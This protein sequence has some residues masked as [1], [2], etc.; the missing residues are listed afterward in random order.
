MSGSRIVLSRQTI[1]FLLLVL[2][3][4]YLFNLGMWFSKDLLLENQ[5]LYFQVLQLE[6][7]IPA[8]SAIVVGVFIFKDTAY[9]GKPR[10]FFL[11]YLLVTA[12]A[13]IM[14]LGRLFLGLDRVDYQ[15][16]ALH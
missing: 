13:A 3:L 16:H 6:M 15:Q 8:F 9:L 14:I 10:I 7:M 12:F 5:Q 1:V 2:G 4:T 11:Y